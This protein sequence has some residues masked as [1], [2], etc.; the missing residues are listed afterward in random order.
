MLKGL[1]IHV[2][3]DIHTTITNILNQRFVIFK[4]VKL[5]SLDLEFKTDFQIP[6]Y[7]GLGK[8]VSLGFGNVSQL[9]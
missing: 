8:S 3:N 4:G 1:E 2:E 5:L 9:K 6:N 7:I